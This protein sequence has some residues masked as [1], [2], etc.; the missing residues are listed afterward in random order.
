MNSYL[1]GLV[2]PSDFRRAASSAFSTGNVYGSVTG[3][4]AAA[5]VEADAPNPVGE[6]AM[7]CLGRERIFEHFSRANHT[8]MS[9]LRLN[10]ATELR[11]GVLVDIAQRVHA[12]HAVHLTMGYLNAIWQGDANAMSLQ[13]LACASC[14]RWCSTSPGRSCSAC[15][16]WPSSSATVWTSP[17]ASK[18]GNQT[19]RC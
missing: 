11:Y 18:A 9:L 7:S 6:Y 3:V 4:C 8:P 2:V 12:G 17:F 5:R 16:A 14:P 10:Y 15:G 13:S 1:P 19:T